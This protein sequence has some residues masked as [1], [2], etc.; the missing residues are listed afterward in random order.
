MMKMKEMI[1]EYAI[2]S[3]RMRINARIFS[4]MHLYIRIMQKTEMK[5]KKDYGVNLGY[6]HVKWEDSRTVK[7][8]SLI[9]LPFSD[10]RSR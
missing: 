3:A 4:D 10:A 8:K 5:N 2:Q 6:E 7:R 9:S 1:S